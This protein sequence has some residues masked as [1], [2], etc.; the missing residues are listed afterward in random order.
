[1]GGVW[2]CFLFHF[3]GQPNFTQKKYLTALP[4]TG[5]GSLYKTG[6]LAASARALL[7]GEIAGHPVEPVA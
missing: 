5:Q 1:V 4:F 3:P 6:P 2:Q 7:L